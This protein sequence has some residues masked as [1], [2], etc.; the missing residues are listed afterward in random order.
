[1]YTRNSVRTNMPTLCS[2]LLL[3]QVRYA[4][5]HLYI[6]AGSGPQDNRQLFFARAPASTTEEDLRQLFGQYGQVESIT[7]FRERRTH[8]SKGCG[9]VTMGDRDQAVAVSCVW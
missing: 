4:R 2:H 6:Q 3:F 9:F 8:A 5:S 7:L 1:M